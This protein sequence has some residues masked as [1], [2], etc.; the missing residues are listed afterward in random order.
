MY[1]LLWLLGTFGFTLIAAYLARKGGV[2]YLIGIY[3][4][5]M[6]I[7]NALG[8]KLILFLGFN[9]N[10]GII[11]ISASFLVSDM[12]CEFFGKQHAS[13]A[14][15]IGILSMIL[16]MIT[17]YLAVNW[18][19]A[20]MFRYQESYAILFGTSARLALAQIITN[21]VAQNHDVWAFYFWKRVTR[22]RWLWLRNNLST[23]SSQIIST[24]LFFTIAFY[25]V[26]DIIPLITG[27]IMAKVI[28][29]ILDTPFI[30]IARYLYARP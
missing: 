14:V 5:I 26:Y 18:P 4:G 11:L 9:A 6:I 25:G 7:M 27:T 2:T 3:V 29:S 23:I 1:E 17:S 16:F 21:I 19:A 12:I 28:I 30:Y 15:W 10:V 8:S 24:I 22:G 13:R 20:T